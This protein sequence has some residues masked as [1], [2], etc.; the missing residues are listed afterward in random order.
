M[1][2]LLACALVACAPDVDFLWGRHNMETHS[3]GFALVL[4]LAAWVWTRSQWWG[5]I[6][7]LAVGT[8][9]VFDWLGSDDAAPLGVMAWWPVTERFFFAEAFVFEAI[10]RRYWQPGFVSHNVMAVVREVLLL[11][12]VAGLLYFARIRGRR[13][14]ASHVHALQAVGSPGGPQRHRDS[15]NAQSFHSLPE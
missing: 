1:T 2:G 6:V 15:E 8:H 9:V 7:A 5:V 4:G 14:H 3:A 12:P 13:S 10:S 11:A